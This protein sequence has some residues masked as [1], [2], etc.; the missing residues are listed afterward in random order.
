MGRSRT[1]D[2]SHA[3]T[4]RNPLSLSD[5]LVGLAL[6]NPILSFSVYPDPDG[7]KRSIR[8]KTPCR[9]DLAESAA[10]SLSLHSCTSPAPAGHSLQG[11]LPGA[12]AGSRGLQQPLRRGPAAAPH[13]LRPRQARRRRQRSVGV[14]L[15]QLRRSG[16]RSGVER[17]RGRLQR[18]RGRRRRRCHQRVWRCQYGSGVAGADGWAGGSR[19][20]RRGGPGWRRRLVR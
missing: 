6:A 15:L 7:W 13:P 5:C 19:R 2:R 20:R 11:G 10:P 12:A 9:T 8:R 14:Q 3:M 4:T 18:V 17:A 16:R 1:A